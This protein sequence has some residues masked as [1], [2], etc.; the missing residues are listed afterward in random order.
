[1]GYSK[2]SYKTDVY[3]DRDLPQET[4]I[5]NDLALYT[6]EPEKEQPKPKASRR[7]K[8]KSKIRTEIKRD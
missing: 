2:S 5:S 3:S 7:G 1:M 4:K 8:K 6:K